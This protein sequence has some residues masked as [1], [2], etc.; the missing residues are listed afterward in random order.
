MAAASALRLAPG[1]AALASHGPWTAK[2]RPGR[3][4]YRAFRTV[5]REGP[6]TPRAVEGEIPRDLCG[7]LYRNGPGQKETFD[8]PLGHL[9]D[10]DAYLT[11]LRFAEGRLSG[12]SRFVMTPERKHELASGRMRYHEF[13]TRCPGRAL[14]FKNPPNI[15]VFPMADG[16]F[17]LSEGAPPVLIDPDTLECLG[18]RDFAG[19]WPA[20]T[21]FT[22]HPKRDP[23]TGDVF[24]Y[25]MTMTLFPELVLGRLAA[26][27]SAFAI[28]ARAPL[29]GVYPVHDFM[30]TQSYVVVALPPVYISMW[31]LLR[32]R[33][34]AESIVAEPHKPLRILVA[35]KDGTKPPVTIE[36]HPA[37]M[38]FHHCNA[39]ESEDGRTIRLISIET[40]AVAGFR[41]LEGWGRATTLAHPK[42]QMTEFVIDVEAKTVA[43]T[44]LTEGAP[45][46]FPAIDQRGLG[47]RMDAIYALRTF[48][49]PDDPLAF[50]TITRWDGAGFR[51][52]RARRGQVFGEPVVVPDAAGGAWIAHLGYEA[53][54]DETF[55]DIRDPDDLRLVARAWFGFRMPL[56]F[57][58]H[59]V[60]DVG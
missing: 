22:A 7:T 8:V 19:S 18:A 57:H 26:G 55:L 52:S 42:S 60:P 30:I 31:G 15:N 43:R 16:H 56:G 4:S 51:E 3:L 33:C 45:I 48:D 34:L 58:G 2:S 46:E 29:G 20:R 6:W 11:A 27:E 36:S 28:F 25:G 17:A 41:A 10:G 59:Y 24:A 13:G 40:E 54:R 38:I 35:R 12:L 47:R 5:T 9:F 50:D 49:A 39:V 21:T 37:N 1:F 32:G 23:A 14:G 53:D 44:A